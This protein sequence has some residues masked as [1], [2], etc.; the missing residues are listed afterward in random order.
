MRRAAIVGLW[1][2]MAFGAGACT[3]ISV[4]RYQTAEPLAKGEQRAS[5]GFQ[6][7]KSGDTGTDYTQL[8]DA[9]VDV[10]HGPVLVLNNLD[11]E[12]RR[13]IT[14][15]TEIQAQAF[16]LGGRASVRYTFLSRG[17]LHAAAGA[18]AG[19]FLGTRV[20]SNS[21]GT[22]F[23]F[24]LTV[25][26]RRD[27]GLALYGG[28]T[29]SRFNV[30]RWVED[31]SKPEDKYLRRARLWQLGGFVGFAVG[32]RLQF[33]PGFTFYLE[34]DEYPIPVFPHRS[35]FVYPWIGM[36]MDTSVLFGGGNTRRRSAP[37]PVPPP[38]DAIEPSPAD[39]PL[40]GAPLHDEPPEEIP[41][42]GRPLHDEP[43]EDLLSDGRPL[44]EEP[45]EDL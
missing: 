23:D 12:Y 32:E 3:P 45:P 26:W 18:G 7:P 43:P 31:D 27:P 1:L 29:A 11:V 33:H 38:S 2:L 5:A 14:D 16:M 22:Y 44:H 4:S 15:R 34:P 20:G 40:P 39:D 6:I 21:A 17:G 24:P 19:A 37:P 25:S 36:S 8:R 13:G 35:V 41:P 28:V 42:A 10:D 9:P 30:S